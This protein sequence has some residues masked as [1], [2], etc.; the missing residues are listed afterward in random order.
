MTAGLASAALLAIV[1]VVALRWLTGEHRRIRAERAQL[2]H[3]H[4]N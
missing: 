1:I 3:D 4:W 2:D